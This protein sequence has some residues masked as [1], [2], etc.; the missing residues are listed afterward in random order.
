VSTSL[1][2]RGVLTDLFLEYLEEATPADIKVGDAIKPDGV[3]WEPGQPQEGAFVPYV[4]VATAPALP[5]RAEPDS[6]AG[7]HNAWVMSYLLTSCGGV[8]TQ[9]DYVG[10]EVRAA[11]VAFIDRSPLDLGDETW[12]IES[13]RF[14]RLGSVDRNDA[15]DP[16]MWQIGDQVNIRITRGLKRR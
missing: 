14:D 10:D 7:A 15:T 16:P 12:S 3:G 9:A 2:V 8:R 5:A 13:V 6:I 11:A 4:T 1:P